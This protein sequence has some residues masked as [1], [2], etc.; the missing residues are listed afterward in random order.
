[1]KQYGQRPFLRLISGEIMKGKIFLIDNDPT[2]VKMFENN[3]SKADIVT[4]PVRDVHEAL[5]KI[6]QT[7]PDV[8]ISDTMMPGRDGYE[9][10]RYLRKDPT[11]AFI[12]FVLLSDKTSI[13]DQVEGFRMGVDDYVCKP[14]ESEDFIER[15]QRIIQRTFKARSYNTQADF[16]GNLR[17]MKIV[18]II[19]LIEVNHKTGELVFHSPKGKQI[20]KAFFQNGNL[21]HAHLGALSGEEAFY[22]LMEKTDG[23]FE[24]FEIYADT[25]ETITI[26]NMS[27]LLNGTR[28]IDEASGIEKIIPDKDCQLCIKSREVSSALEN[29]IGKENITYL[30][31]LIE[32]GVSIQNML[33]SDNLSRPRIASALIHLL[34]EE[35]L[36]VNNDFTD[37][38]V[39]MDK[40][41][42]HKIFEA[43][44]QELSGALEI[45]NDSLNASIYFQN[46]EIIHAICGM[47]CGKKA[48]FRILSQI[49]Q[50]LKFS[51]ESLSDIK[52]IQSPLDILLID[53]VREMKSLKLVN[54]KLLDNTISINS[55]RLHQITSEDKHEELI[56]I[57]ELIKKHGRIGDIL[58]A[59]Q[60]TDLETFKAILELKNLKVIDLS[61][62]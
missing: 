60:L 12:P 2:L 10:L 9:L 41:L 32:K 33:K 29:K 57:V 55:D 45:H 7:K 8:I 39:Q 11:T 38:K 59:S 13:P 30:F 51:F 16:S 37:S 25:V 61:Q 17:Q 14:F 46:G 22:G 18:D 31:Q 44:A 56:P 40:E 19:Q 1:V 5:E 53:A 42:L 23:H 3:L 21:V 15:V 43:N 52:S 27:V 47:T 34:N 58:E 6:H 54:N 50:E 24:F 36:E 48:L 26:P 62:N 35:I 49:A 4:C 20:G 28:L